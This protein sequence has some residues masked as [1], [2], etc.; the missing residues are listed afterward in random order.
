MQAGVR[1]PAVVAPSVTFR[2]PRISSSALGAAKNF[3][4]Y[5]GKSELRPPA[6]VDPAIVFRPIQVFDTKWTPPRFVTSTLQPPTVTGAVVTP[7]LAYPVAVHLAK[8]AQRIQV[9]WKLQKPAVV[10]PVLVFRPVERALVTRPY[11]SQRTR[12]QLRLPAVTGDAIIFRAPKIELAQTPRRYY[13]TRNRL[14][15]PTVLAFFAR[16]I[17]IS[18]ALR[19]KL[20]W[21]APDSKLRPPAAVDASVTFR[22]VQTKLVRN[23]GGKPKSR[24]N[25]P[26]VLGAVVVT[27]FRPV[28]V[29][30]TKVLPFKRPAS[31]LRPP[32]SVGDALTFRPVQKTLVQP[33]RQSRKNVSDLR[34]PTIL[35]FLAY[36]IRVLNS[37]WRPPTPTHPKLRPPAVIDA[38]TVFRAV[39]VYVVEPPVQ[40]VR[41]AKSRLSL[42]VAPAAPVI[43]RALQVHLVQPPMQAVRK[44]KARLQAPTVV[45]AAVVF[46][47]I[48]IHLV[49]PPVQAVRKARSILRAP[50]AVSIFLAYP[51]RVLL[52]KTFLRSKPPRTQGE[53]R[54]PIVVAASLTFRP[55]FVKLVRRPRQAGG[56]RNVGWRKV[57]GLQDILQFVTGFFDQPT[58]GDDTDRAHPH[59][60]T[61]DGPA[62]GADMDPG[63][64]DGTFF[65]D[66]DPRKN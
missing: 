14:A 23:P 7:T 12:Y 61:F 2:P 9:H 22:P 60:Q 19:E 28:Q 44:A 58:V 65:D 42:P 16:A 59:G 25:P 31:R 29:A 10:D 26:S 21:R 47:A 34:P 8:F 57:P 27:V 50:A 54:P 20:P 3:A 35:Y 45:G 48:Q 53:I 41:K 15:P 46:R 51:I 64:P 38:A 56:A 62:P 6:A 1:P 36:P 32:S 52:A 11:V 33:P 13:K 49:Q 24:L 18:L 4:R 66:P 43:G 40:A 39:R 5:Q 17:Q 37:K 63:S 30:L 55:P